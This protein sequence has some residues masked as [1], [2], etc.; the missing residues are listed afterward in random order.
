VYASKPALKGTV[1]D[2]K[3]GEPIRKFRVRARKLQTLRGAHYV[4]KDQ[5]MHFEN[6]RGEFGVET[7]GPGVYQA[8]AA[9]EGYAPVWSQEINTDSAEPIVMTLTSGGAIAGRVVDVEGRPITS[10]KVIPLSIAGGAMPTTKD[11]FVC[12][13]GAVETVDGAFTLQN[14][15]A[16]EE[17]LKTT[18]PDYAFR[19]VENVRVV[20]G[21]TTQ[22]VDIVLTQGGT[23]EG[24]VY[25]DKGVPQGNEVLYFRTTAASGSGDGR[26]GGWAPR[27][28]ATASTACPTCPRRCA[29]SGGRTS[30]EDW[31]S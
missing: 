24:Y 29:T 7:V 15:P 3:T 25:D 6:E 11:T 27:S 23:V 19:I 8:Q 10:A 9:A 14:L 17:T 16:G 2:T 31:A 26:P 12:E 28:P 5:W 18:H 22:A 4:Q 1:V 21:M 13:D 20:G 30:G